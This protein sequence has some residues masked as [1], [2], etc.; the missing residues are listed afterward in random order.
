MQRHRV[1]VV[2]AGYAGVVALSPL[3]RAVF[4]LREVFDIS[5]EEIAEMVET[6]ASA[7]RQLLHRAR[8]HVRAHRPRFRPSRDQQT[9]LALE[10]DG[11][12]VWAIRFVFNPD[13]LRSIDVPVRP[14]L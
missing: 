12:R 5:F 10:S 2:G 3:E 1:L 4:I 8:E 9:R 6:S 7:C 14:A 11:A 13:K